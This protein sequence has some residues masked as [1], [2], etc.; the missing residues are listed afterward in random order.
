MILPN[1]GAV[2]FSVALPPPCSGANAIRAGVRMS[3][4]IS[5]SRLSAWLATRRVAILDAIVV[6]TC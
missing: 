1:F 5:S 2:F 6:E 3:M 4:R